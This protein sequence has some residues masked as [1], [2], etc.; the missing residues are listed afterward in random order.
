MRTLNVLKVLLWINI[1]YTRNAAIQ[2]KCEIVT[3]I[4]YSEYNILIIN[5]IN[6]KGITTLDYFSVLSFYDNIKSKYF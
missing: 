6:C 4:N 3:Q 2:Q 5:Y 1:I